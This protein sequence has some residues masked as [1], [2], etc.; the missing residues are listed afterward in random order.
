MKSIV[1]TPRVQG[2]LKLMDMDIPQ[3][4]E[5]EVLL[6]VLKVGVCGT[7]R[8]IIAGFYGEAPEG[9]SYLVIGHE[10]LCRIEEVGSGVDTFRKGELVV[11]TVRRNCPENCESC[12]N[13]M[14][15]MCLTG[16]YKEHGIK[17]LHGFARE[18]AISDSG[19]IVKLPES[20]SDAGILLEPLTI[21][22][23]G[24]SVSYAMQN[25]RLPWRPE[26]AIVLGA[27]PV[28][29]LATA[30][31]RLKGLE[32]DTVA[33]RPEDSLKA[34]LAEQTGASYINAAKNPLA[35]LENRYDL[36]LEVTGNVSVAVEAQKL[37]RVNGIVSYL[38][39]Y[40][41]TTATE[42]AGKIFT[43]LVLGN[44]VYFGS[45]NANKKYF[46]AGVDDLIRIQQEWSGFLGKMITKRVRP[47]GLSEAY[48]PVGPDGIKNIIE[49]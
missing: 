46:Q 24:I 39:I 25:S 11:P 49:F 22:E 20:L 15:D 43:D 28:G 36:V 29:L 31:L 18:Y 48:G 34:R 37:A 9:S 10:S 3:V 47:E 16:H 41:E 14:S 40:K 42:D 32:V 6:K 35:T 2:S 12:R 23:K 27:G 7:D 26:R 44:R 8:D 13:G 30:V 5:K 45:V 21:V 1:V 17:Q 33:T 19:F 38:G 4:G